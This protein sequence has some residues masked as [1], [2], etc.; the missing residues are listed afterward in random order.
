MALGN[1]DYG[2]LGLIVGFTNF[3]TFFN[4]LFSGAIGRFFAYSIGKAR[5]GTDKKMKMSVAN[6]S[7]LH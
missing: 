3:I 2:L 5:K 1:S 4:T 7:I 6:G